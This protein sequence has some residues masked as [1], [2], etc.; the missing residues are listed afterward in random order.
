MLATRPEG[1]ERESMLNN[2]MTGKDA[3]KIEFVDYILSKVLA[4]LENDGYIM[5]K[6]ALRMFRSP[7]LRDYWFAKFVE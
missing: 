4:M 7:L 1:I 6:G 5:K 2:L 3:S